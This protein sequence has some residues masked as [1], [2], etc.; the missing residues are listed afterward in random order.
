[1]GGRWR[2]WR[3]EVMTVEARMSERST[4]EVEREWWREVGREWE[5]EERS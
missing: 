3:E 5:R 2:E 1:M 4:G